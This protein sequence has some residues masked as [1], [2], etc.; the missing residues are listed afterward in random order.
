VSPAI[1]WPCDLIW[2]GV[3]ITPGFTIELSMPTMV[4][5]F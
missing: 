2:Q 3:T 4:E 1:P 5:M